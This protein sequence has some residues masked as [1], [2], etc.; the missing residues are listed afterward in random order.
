METFKRKGRTFLSFF[1]SL[2]GLSVV[3]IL[4]MLFVVGIQPFKTLQ[5]CQLGSIFFLKIVDKSEKS[6]TTD[7]RNTNGYYEL[8]F[9]Y[10]DK[11]IINGWFR[12]G[13]FFLMISFEDPE[14]GSFCCYIFFCFSLWFF[15]CI[16]HFF[17]FLS[18]FFTFSN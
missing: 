10:F 1:F 3:E 14:L 9:Y 7:T 17:F 8:L 18:T 12:F 15:F 2:V 4:Y 13:S 6:F 11:I 16:F 5:V